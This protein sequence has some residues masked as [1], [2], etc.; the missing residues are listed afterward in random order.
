[1]DGSAAGAACGPG[2]KISVKCFSI[3]YE[4]GF[5]LH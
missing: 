3:S 1:M 2:V 5:L 4:I